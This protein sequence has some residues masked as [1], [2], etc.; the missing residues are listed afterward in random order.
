ME[1]K[2]FSS[3]TMTVPI[4]ELVGRVDAYGAP[5]VGEWL[6]NNATASP[7]HLVVDLSRVPFM[8]S[9]ALATLIQGRKRC[10][11][12][13]GDLVLCALQNPVRATIELMQLHRVFRIFPTQAEALAAFDG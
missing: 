12:G 1:L 4:L 3:G 2:L 11:A 6:T 13:G 8:D 10:C 7:P 9:T 5:A